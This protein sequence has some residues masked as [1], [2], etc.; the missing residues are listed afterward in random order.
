[1][2]EFQEYLRA[3]ET[4]VY[5][6]FLRAHA[7]IMRDLEKTLQD[8]VGIS[9]TWLDV[10]TQ[11]ARAD[12]HRMTHTQ[13]S[14]RRLVGGS[15][16]ITRLVD[17]MAKAGLVTRRASRKDRRTSYVVMTD[18][19]R[20]MYERASLAGSRVVREHFTDHVKPEEAQPLRSFFGR[21]LGE[22][23]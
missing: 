19:G 22:D 9:I 11:L 2:Q 10:L 21:V 13:L 1:M 18:A 15:G 6:M 8:E 20:E 4:R 17:R 7:S 23:V 12:G 3:P 16:G 14:Q 5:L